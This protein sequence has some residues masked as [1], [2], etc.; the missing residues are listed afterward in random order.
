M[1]D[2]TR[3]AGSKFGD[4]IA[5]LTASNTDLIVGQGEIIKTM[6]DQNAQLVSLVGE[7]SSRLDAVEARLPVDGANE[8]IVIESE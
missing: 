6:I 4:S 7:L 8:P 2:E 5:R 1:C 3:E